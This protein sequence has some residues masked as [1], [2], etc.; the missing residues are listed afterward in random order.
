MAFSQDTIEAKVRENC[1]DIDAST[2]P[3]VRF[4]PYFLEAER[5][6]YDNVQGAKIGATG[7]ITAFVAAATKSTSSILDDQYQNAIADYMAYSYFN[8]DR[9]DKRDAARADNFLARFLA[10]FGKTKL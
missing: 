10:H 2:W 9:G 4:F 8:A 7:A 6:I 5:W 3:D 1:N